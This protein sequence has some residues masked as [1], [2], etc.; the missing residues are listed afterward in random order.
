VALPLAG[1]ALQHLPHRLR[2]RGN[3]QGPDAQDGAIGL[4]QAVAVERLLAPQA[5]DRP[6][7]LRHPLELHQQGA[8]DVLQLVLPVDGL[9]HRT[10]IDGCDRRTTRGQLLE[11]RPQL[12]EPALDA[13]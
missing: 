10:V 11:G 5:L 6:R 13:A 12:R 1:Q 3:E 8:E 7:P 4:F 2:R 9:R